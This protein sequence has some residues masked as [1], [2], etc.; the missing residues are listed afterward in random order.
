[1]ASDAPEP[2]V[3]PRRV[4]IV[5]GAGGGIGAAVAVSLAAN[6]LAVMAADIAPEAAAATARTITARGGDALGL[7]V[8]V[9]RRASVAQ[10]LDATLTRFGRL[11]VLVN[12][13]GIIDYAPVLELTEA[14]WDRVL[15]VNL[16]GAFLCAQAAAA[17][18]AERG[19]AG[20]V[21][22]VTSIS[23][24]LPEPD[25]LHYGVS[26]AGLAYLTRALALGLAPC[27]IR[28]VA[29]APGTIRTPMNSDLL[30]DP[31]V[32][33]SR[34]ATIPLRRFGEPVDIADAVAFLVSDA[35]RYVT[36]STLYVEVG[37]MLVR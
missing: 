2:A 22:N 30:R 5:T 18:M 16:K 28:V 8:D 20:I 12:N 25:C 36:G 34:L 33:E 26:K 23:A 24:E 29:V 10:L 15:A 7:H 27:G 37:M 19:A 31:A 3:G 35:A 11:D 21:V 1:V 13:A 14:A 32:V 9:T 17:A 6:G 4:A